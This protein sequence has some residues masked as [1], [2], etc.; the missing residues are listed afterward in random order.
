MKRIGKRIKID[1]NNINSFIIDLLLFKHQFSFKSFFNLINKLIMINYIHLNLGIFDFIYNRKIDEKYLFKFNINNENEFKTYYLNYDLLINN[2]DI[3]S[4]EKIDIKGLNKINNNLNKIEEIIEDNEINISDINLSIGLKKYLIKSFN[5]VE[6][7]YCEDDIQKINFKKLIQNKK[8]NNLKYINITIGDISNLN[9][10]NYLSDNNKYL[11][12]LIKNSKNL[13]SIILRL[14]TDN[15]NETIKFILYLIEDLKKLRIF[16]ISQYLSQSKFDITFEQLI[17]QFPKLKNRI[18][19]FK[20]FKINNI[21]FENKINDNI[22][23]N[24]KENTIICIHN[25]KKINIPIQILGYNKN[26][27]NKYCK[28]YLNNEKIKFCL[29]YKFPETRQYEIKIKYKI[30]LKDMSYMFYK[31]SSLNSL[32]LSNFNTNNVKNMN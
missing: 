8:L 9:K 11:F 15:L 22:E 6:S 10:D 12:E 31:C 18:Y 19:Y 5:D 26:N 20:E 29:Q 2:R 1:Y 7:I 24:Q 16:N 14:K 17:K 28:L 13:K 21:G 27:N 25:I 4:Y 30:I 32:N 23:K 3:I